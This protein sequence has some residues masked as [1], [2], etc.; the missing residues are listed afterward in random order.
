MTPTKDAPSGRTPWRWPVW[1]GDLVAAVLIVGTA[2]AQY[3]G[4]ELLPGNPLGFAAAVAPAAILPLRRRWPIPIL[5]ACIALFA[6]MAF[7]G[8]IGAG[9]EIATAIAVFG[10]A[11]RTDRRTTLIT[12]VIT[13]VLLVGIGL[14]SGIGSPFEPRTFQYAVTIGFAAAAGEAT[15]SRRAYI[16]AITERAER[17]EETRESEARR[18]V[19][20][21]R[22]RIARD[23]HDAV[24]HQISVISLNAGVASSALESRPDAAREAL[25]TIRSAARTV[26]GEIGDLLAML[27]SE[28]PAGS[29]AASGAAPQPGLDRIDE[30]IARFGESGL[31]VTLRVDGDLTRLP[32]ATDLVAYRVLQEALTNAH[33]HGGDHRAH[34]LVEVGPDAARLVVTNPVADRGGAT[35]TAAAG[36]G[37][38]LLGIRERVASVRGTVEAGPGPGGYRLSAMLPVPLPADRVGP[39]HPSPDRGTVDPR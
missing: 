15:R 5:V 18:R 26:L 8:A 37:H 10:V 11:V 35:A 3:P 1:V 9:A 12:A 30:L 7:A 33:K 13:A 31:D 28:E 24:A 39:R 29:S 14:L 25:A 22:L 17:A 20:E 21:D 2:A 4:H 23:L 34:V 36:A 38:G 32:V 19:A 16:A 6:I 27:R